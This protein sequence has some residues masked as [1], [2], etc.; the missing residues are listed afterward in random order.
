MEYAPE[1]LIR[2]EMEFVDLLCHPEM[3]VGI[4]KLCYKRYPRVNGHMLEDIEN[5]GFPYR[6]KECLDFLASVNGFRQG[7][8]DAYIN[9]TKT[10]S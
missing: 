8:R 5:R 9:Q 2:L 3:S 6:S 10:T 7:G 1:H 4:L